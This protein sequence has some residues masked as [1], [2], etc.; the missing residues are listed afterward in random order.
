MWNSNKWLRTHQST[1]DESLNPPF[2]QRALSPRTPDES[3]RLVHCTVMA[4]MGTCFGAVHT[5]YHENESP[6]SGSYT[7]PYGSPSTGE[8]NGLATSSAC[9]N[10]RPFAFSWNSSPR[11]VPSDLPTA[12]A[13][14]FAITEIRQVDC[15]CTAVFKIY[16]SFGFCRHF[17]MT[18]PRSRFQR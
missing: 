17:Y 9:A 3:S 15:S 18:N 7:P 8:I 11:G 16:L 6:L 14:T 10:V 1:L 13:R 4:S 5:T 12:V 2:V